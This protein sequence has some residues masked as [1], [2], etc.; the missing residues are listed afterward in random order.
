MTIKYEIDVPPIK[1][2]RAGVSGKRFYDTQVKEKIA[3]GLFLTK[4]H[5]SNPKLTKP[6]HLDVTFHMKIPKEVPAKK[7]PFLTW[8]MVTPD[9]DNCV[10]FLMDA[11][12]NTNTIWLDDKQ[13]AKIT[14]Q[15]IYSLNPHVSFSLTELD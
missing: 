2:A 15:K 14:A 13:V 9:L 7:R 4:C 6:L 1:W 5:A 11:I 12:N 10:K 3:Y 8:H